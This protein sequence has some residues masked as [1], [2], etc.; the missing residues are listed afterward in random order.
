MAATDNF[1][2]KWRCLVILE[3]L[4]KGV[5]CCSGCMVFWGVESAKC[6]DQVRFRENSV[7]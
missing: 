4:V 2:S 7:M 6:V 3:Q 5:G 1:H